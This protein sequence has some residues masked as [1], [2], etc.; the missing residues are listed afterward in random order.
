MASPRKVKE[1]TADTG[2]RILRPVQALRYLIREI[3]KMK[4]TKQ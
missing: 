3:K 1:T 4:K 2:N